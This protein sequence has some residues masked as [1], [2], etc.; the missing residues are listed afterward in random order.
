MQQAQWMSHRA[1]VLRA[2]RDLL[3][4]IKRQPQGNVHEM[5]VEARKEMKSG[6]LESDPV[7]ASEK[8]KQL[9]G[10]VS[11]LHMTTP[12]QFGDRRSR[13]ESA[14]YVVR[15]GVLTEG[16]AEDREK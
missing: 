10:R 12:R 16:E 3:D 11:F 4:L 15:D 8:L 6:M 5:L 14:Q 9:V 1:N 7:E 2:Y 13:L